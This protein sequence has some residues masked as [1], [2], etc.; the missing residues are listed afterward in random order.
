M[1]KLENLT[2]Y[3]KK[4]S[5]IIE[6]LQ[7]YLNLEDWKIIYKLVEWTESVGELAE[8][9]YSRFSALIHFRK[10]YV[11][12]VDNEAIIDLVMHEL[13]HIITTAPLIIFRDDKWTKEQ[14]WNLYYCEMINNMNFANEQMNT[15]LTT[16]MMREFK[17]TDSY[18]KL[19]TKI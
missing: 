12:E 18:K 5:K 19:L 4:I 11:E 2:I 3:M 9:D 6:T 16:I 10:D 17:M 8:T 1:R 7:D 14:F 13:C 15:K